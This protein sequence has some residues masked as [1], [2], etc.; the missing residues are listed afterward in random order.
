MPDAP[1]QGHTL[2]ESFIE[3]IFAS[4]PQLTGWPA[5][6]DSRNFREASNHPSVND[7]G[8]E[9]YLSHVMN[10]ALF[11]DYQRWEP[12]G[13]MYLARVLQDDLPESQRSPEPLKAL[14]F[15]LIILRIAERLEVGR[16]IYL[17]L[18]APPTSQASFMFQINKLRGRTLTSWSNPGRYISPGRVAEQD[19]ATAFCELTL[20]AGQQ[21]IVD[22][23]HY[24]AN[25]VFHLFGGF[26]ISRKVTADLVE[27]LLQRRW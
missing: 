16:R 14:D 25:E 3:R 5:W 9:A 18:G 23:T 6:L 19:V 8:W 21:L 22:K 10:E 13:R 27:N 7:G 2:N 20:D 15:S 12:S 17:G 1:L 4:N 26:E 24:V 11:T